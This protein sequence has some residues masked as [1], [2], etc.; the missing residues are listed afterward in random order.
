MKREYNNNIGFGTINL[1]IYNR[2]G[3]RSHGK[4]DHENV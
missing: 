4:Y 2:T 1:F 3:Y